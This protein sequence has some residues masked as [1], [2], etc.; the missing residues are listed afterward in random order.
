[1]LR[2]KP[3]GPC[4]LVG[5]SYGRAVITEAGVHPQVAALV[6]IAALRTYERDD[7]AFVW[8][9]IQPT[10]W[11]MGSALDASGGHHALG[12]SFLEDKVSNRRWDRSHHRDGGCF[13]EGDP[14][15]GL[16]LGHTDGNR[17]HRR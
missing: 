14:V 6:Y 8:K 5:H 15:R 10:L 12:H 17:Q 2:A 11:A 9:P 4:V 1:M 16:D 13:G 3:I 7:L